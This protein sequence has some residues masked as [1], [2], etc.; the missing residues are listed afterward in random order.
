MLER[1]GIWRMRVVL[2][3]KEAGLCEQELVNT[4]NGTGRSKE[5]IVGILEW[6]PAMA[7]HC[8]S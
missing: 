1:D 6:Q 7:L 2:V 5:R 4:L 3:R 8:Q